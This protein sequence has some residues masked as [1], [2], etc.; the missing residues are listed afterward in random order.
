M[1]DV[2]VF[3]LRVVSEIRDLA[4]GIKENDRQ[5]SRLIKRVT[6]VEAP[7]LAVKQGTRLSSSES[8]RQLLA[9]VKKIRDFLDKYAR[10]RKIDRALRRK[11]NA[12]KFTR[13][14]AIL[15]EGMQALQLDVAVDMWA[16]E[17]ASDRMDDLENMLDAVEIM[18]RN[19]TG[20]H[21]EIMGALKV[22]LEGAT[23]LRCAS[24]SGAFH[25]YRALLCRFRS[26][27]RLLV[28]ARS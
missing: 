15:T 20:N 23:V 1:A 8:L 12:E 24:N 25:N 7:V 3:I 5:A 10:T 21:A 26:P 6:A 17:D 22:S 16:K 27:F 9:T 13:L 2:A 19:Q 11:P 28:S 14:G 18:Q 4:E